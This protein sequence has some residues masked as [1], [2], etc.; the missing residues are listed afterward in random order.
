MANDTEQAIIIS[1]WPCTGKSTFAKTWT[2]HTVFDLDSSAYDLKSP[3]GTEKYVEDIQ[4]RSRDSPSSII[5]VSSH[6]E[7]RQLLKERRLKYVA[8]S[9]H[10]LEDWE[11]RQKGR[12]TGDEDFA[13]IGLLKKGISE[14][15]SWKQREAG[16]EPKVVLKREQYL[17]NQIIVDEILELAKGDI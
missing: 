5:L 10:E 12:V 7:V 11:E 2:G 14:W 16:E 8:V 17:G 15:D 4:A 13:Q 3:A 6:A 1:A 9:V